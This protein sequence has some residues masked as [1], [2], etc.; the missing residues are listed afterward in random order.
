MRIHRAGDAFRLHSRE[1]RSENLVAGSSRTDFLQR[2]VLHRVRVRER[3][4]ET[5][6]RVGLAGLQDVGEMLRVG[7]EARHRDAD[8]AMQ[9]VAGLNDRIVTE[10]F[11]GHAFALHADAWLEPRAQSLI[12]RALAPPPDE[13]A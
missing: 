1:H 3:L 8:V 11:G 4:L 5:G 2:E 7:I 9:Y 13:I 12:V 10:L 6:R